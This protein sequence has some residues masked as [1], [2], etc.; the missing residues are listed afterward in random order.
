MRWADGSAT[1]RVGRAVPVDWA[2]VVVAQMLSVSPG[3]LFAE[4]GVTGSSKSGS[5]RQS[6]F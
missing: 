3:A 1:V 4:T 5:K 6:G 2:G